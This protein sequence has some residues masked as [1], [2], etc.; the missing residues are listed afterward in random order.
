M[1]AILQLPTQALLIFCLLLMG[2]ISTSSLVPVMG[3]FIVEGLGEPAWK[4]GFYTGLVAILTLIAN[5]KFGS[6]LD[7][8]ARPRD[9]LFVA[10]LAFLGFASL[11]ASGPSFLLVV[12]VGAPLMSLANTAT[13]T[14]FT[15]GRLYANQN[16][17]NAGHYNALLRTAV[18]LAW[19]IGPAMSFVMIAE[20]GFQ[21]SFAISAFAGLF[22]LTVWFFCVPKDFRSNSKPKPTAKGLGVDWALWLA[23]LACM[24]FALANVLFVTVLP[25][26]LIREVKLPGFTPGL[27]LSV[28]CLVEVIAIF[29]SARLADQFGAR[30]VMSGAALLAI[31]AF[32]L[33]SQVQ[34]IPEV[35]GFA[36][37]EGIYYGLFA[38]VSVTFIQSFA[39]DKPGRATA[40]YMN[41]LFFGGMIGSV[42]MGII[43]SNLSFQAVVLCS[44]G[45]G[46]CA[47]VTLFLT[48][49]L[50]PRI[51]PAS[52][53]PN[54]APE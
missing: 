34:S 35:M 24:F 52:S 32:V 41:S 26:F 10:I 3:Y 19:M 42:S 43:A 48:R 50:Q 9:L 7:A 38:G 16:D 29:S 13:A 28:K 15:F 21:R 8:G 14:T 2:A 6:L 53:E 5:R 17:L 54:Q 51:E 45:M 44:A 12:V 4:V 37:L 30:R 39:P 25:L 1:R 49:K 20:I 46:A 11:L 33:F 27:A 31:V 36:V 40:L 22:W 23:A 47:F 18:S